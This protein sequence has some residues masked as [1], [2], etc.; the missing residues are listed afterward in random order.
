MMPRYPWK[1]EWAFALTPEQL[2]NHGLHFTV[3]LI[4]SVAL[5]IVGLPAAAAWP[6]FPAAAITKELG[7]A[8]WKAVQGRRIH[9]PDSWLDIVG[10]VAGGYAPWLI[11][12]WLA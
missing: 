3:M 6:L 11:R 1:E 9:L 2:G 8:H 7:E 10:L 12:W 5:M 4:A